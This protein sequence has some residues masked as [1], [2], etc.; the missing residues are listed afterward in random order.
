MLK[1]VSKKDLPTLQ[2]MMEERENLLQVLAST[3][4]EN[5]N[6]IQVCDT[7]HLT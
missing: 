6:I 3:Q 7:C 1:G 4:R 5:T 2:G